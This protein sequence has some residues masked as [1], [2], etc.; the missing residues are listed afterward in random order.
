MADSTC[1][2][3]QVGQA[4]VKTA[5]Q[6]RHALSQHLASDPQGRADRAQKKGVLQRPLRFT[7]DQKEACTGLQS[8]LGE[9]VVDGSLRNPRLVRPFKLIAYLVEFF[10]RLTRFVLQF[11]NILG[12]IFFRSFE[13]QAR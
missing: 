8:Q 12:W 9:H 2:R 6:A 1:R 4:V 11:L 10:Y 13:Q 3:V 7:V 5:T